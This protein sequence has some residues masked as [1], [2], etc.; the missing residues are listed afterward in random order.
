VLRWNRIVALVALVAAVPLAVGACAGSGDDT[1][2]ASDEPATTTTTVVTPDATTVS[3]LMTLG[4]PIILAHAGGENTHPHS[5]PF[6]YAQ[7][8]AAGVDVLDFDVQLSKDGV[9]VIQHDDTV[10]RTTN[11]TGKVADMTYDELN[12]LDNAYWFTETCTC[13]DQPE[14]AYI[15]RGVRTGE[16]APPDGAAPDDFVIPR[17]EDIAREY[18]N[19]VL[20]VE[21]KGSYP[22]AVPAAKEL[23]RILR[24]LGRE[25]Q[26]VVTAFDDELSE[27]FHAELP[28]VAITPGLTAMTAYVLQNVLPA[29]GRNIV[30]IPPEYEGIELLTPDFIARAK[31]DGM[32]LWIWPNERSWENAQGYQRL[33]DM[34][35]EGINAADPEVAV[36]TLRA[37]TEAP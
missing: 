37:H 19:F 15:Y 28:S 2:T 31:G 4:R 22:E 16:T 30:Q 36:E 6:G 21:I 10:D 14:T 18:P 13:R 24:E 17:F 5:T 29:D 12:A 3:E 27:A 33:L 1:D 11:A 23:A 25:D 7:S 32:V 35:V 8:V 9:L 34:G 20:N 26:A